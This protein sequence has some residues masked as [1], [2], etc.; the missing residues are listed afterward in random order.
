M[1][2]YVKLKVQSTNLDNLNK[3]INEIKEIVEKLGSEMKG[4][5][6]LPTKRLTFSMRK[7]P[8]GQGTETFERWELRIHKRVVY[9]KIDERVLKAITKLP[10][11][12]D[13]KLE[14]KFLN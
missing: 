11:P 5:I 12:Q 8:D 1:K 13:V 6:P 2:G 10:I 9:L 4:P 3:F 14:L 7:S